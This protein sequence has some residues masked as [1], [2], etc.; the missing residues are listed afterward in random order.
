MKKWNNI[1]IDLFGNHVRFLN[2]EKVNVIC[3]KNN[4]GKS[5]I[6]K[7]LSNKDNWN[8]KYFIGFKLDKSII[9]GLQYP[10]GDPQ[11]NYEADGSYTE[12][13]VGGFHPDIAERLNSAKKCLLELAAKQKDK[14]Y[15]RLDEIKKDILADTNI[16]KHLNGDYFT[17]NETGEMVFEAHISDIDTVFKDYYNAQNGGIKTL[18]IETQREIEPSQEM[19]TVKGILKDLFVSKNAKSFSPHK[20]TKYE[21]LEKSFSSI[22]GGYSFDISIK[23]GDAVTLFFSKDGN[24]WYEAKESGLGLRALLVLL[25]SSILSEEDII[26][27][28]EPESYLHPSWQRELLKYFKN[29]NK[30]F[31]LSTHSNVFLDKLYVDRIFQTKYTNVIEVDN[32]E[33]KTNAL[34]ELGYLSI[35]NLQGDILILVEGKTDIFALSAF[36]KTLGIWNK[37]DIKILQCGGLSGI[38]EM[39]LDTLKKDYH[40]VM[41]LMDGDWIKDKGL[42]NSKVNIEKKCQS[43]NIF[44]KTLEG[45]GIENYFSLAALVKHTGKQNPLSPKE[46][47][48]SGTKPKTKLKVKI[49]SV[50]G[51]KNKK[52]DSFAKIASFMT[53]QEIENMGDL[54]VFLKKAIDVCAT[55]PL[56]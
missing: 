7:I 27:I 55:L 19:S 24:N 37:Y 18:L 25:Y 34:A 48:N 2:L 43:L 31:I 1:R 44:Y 49:E 29:S 40:T 36:F 42:E 32:I 46:I 51:I 35:D 14:I 21:H 15:L 22:S 53:T 50:S 5:T 9:D 6:L 20:Y 47:D 4:T 10:E 12:E 26:L 54:Y 23:D 8:K 17:D 3:G 41:V 39:P 38:D 30:Q 16:S 28:D 56:K 13:W 33:D 45:F 52:A 11:N